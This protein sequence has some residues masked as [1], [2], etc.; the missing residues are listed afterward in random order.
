VSTLK[1]CWQN[2]QLININYNFDRQMST[3]KRYFRYFNNG[4]EHTNTNAGKQ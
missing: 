2:E 1:Y 4:T 3:S